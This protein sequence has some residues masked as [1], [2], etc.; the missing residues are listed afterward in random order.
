MCSY[1]LSV[2]KGE[3][4]EEEGGRE[5]GGE[6]GRE[7]GRQDSGLL[8]ILRGG[9]AQ[10]CMCSPFASSRLLGLHPHI[11]IITGHSP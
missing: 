3:R 7:R 4:E 10:G 9:R 2:G 6:G 5:G 11:I 1:S 8:A